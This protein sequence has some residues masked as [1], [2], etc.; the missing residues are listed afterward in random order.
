MAKVLMAMGIGIAAMGIAAPR[1]GAAYTNLPVA[2]AG[3][4]PDA[5]V[6][7]S[8][9]VPIDG[10][11]PSDA[12]YKLFRNEQQLPGFGLALAYDARLAKKLVLAPYAEWLQE[13]SSGMW[14]NEGDARLAVDSV[15]A[16][17]VVRVPIKT[18]LQ[19]FVR[20]GGGLSFGRASLQLPGG[21]G[22][23]SGNARSAFVRAGAGLMARTPALA[24]MDDLLPAVALSFAIEGG[25]I[26]AGKFDFTVAGPKP[27][28]AGGEDPI[29]VGSIPIGQLGRSRPYMRITLGVHF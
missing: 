14:Q 13:S 15:A 16:G 11:W 8:L 3:S 12:A 23:L 5:R 10:T 26:A 20:V 6:P 9:S 27:A 24:L 28:S 29:A 17:A 25:F 21:G 22:A 19:P 18:W 1:A 7:F 2:T 4:R